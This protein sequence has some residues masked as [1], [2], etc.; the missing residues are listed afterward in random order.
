MYFAHK[1]SR[2]MAAY[3]NN[4]SWA[5]VLLSWFWYIVATTFV[6]FFKLM[7]LTAYLRWFILPR[8]YFKTFSTSFLTEQ[9]CPAKYSLSATGNCTARAK[10]KNR[11]RNGAF[12]LVRKISQREWPETGLGK[13]WLAVVW[14]SA[15]QRYLAQ[16]AQIINQ[17]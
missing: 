10:K 8:L 4:S 7:L 14:S 11:L 2:K 17:F 5:K 3:N 16:G 9:R 13:P 12:W 1:M 15:Q 6:V